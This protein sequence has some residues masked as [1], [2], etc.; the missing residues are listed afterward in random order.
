MAL[1]NSLTRV[2][3]LLS[4]DPEQ[5]SHVI[6]GTYI[7]QQRW[8]KPFLQ[9][10]PLLRLRYN[11]LGLTHCTVGCCQNLFFQH[12]LTFSRAKAIMSRS[13][14]DKPHTGS[15]WTCKRLSAAVTSGAV[16][17]FLMAL[18]ISIDLLLTALLVPLPLDDP[19]SDSNN[20]SRVDNSSMTL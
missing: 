12:S 15:P 7:F 19:S 4:F 10:E 16:M 3:V 17:S 5:T 1:L 18:R 2:L 20:D 13:D 11:S 8:S 9:G 6:F 14:T